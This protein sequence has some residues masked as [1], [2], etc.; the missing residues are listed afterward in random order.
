MFLLVKAPYWNS[1]REEDYYFYSPHAI[2]LCHEI[3]DA[4]YNNTDIK[5]AFARPKYACTT[6]Y[7]FFFLFWHYV[8]LFFF[9]CVYAV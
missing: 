4:G 7:N 2:F 8:L 3:K 1:R 6:G 5:Q 9:Y